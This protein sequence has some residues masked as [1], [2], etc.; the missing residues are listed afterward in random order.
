MKAILPPSKLTKG[1][2]PKLI[3]ICNRGEFLVESKEAKQ[4]FALVVKEEVGPAI[5]VPEKIKPMLEKFQR[6][7]HDELRTNYH[8]EGYPAPYWFDPRSE[9]TQSLTL[10]D[11]SKREWSSKGE[12]QR[13]DSERDTLER[14][15]VHAQYRLFWHQRRMEWTAEPSTR[16]LSDIDS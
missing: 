14:A 11:E 9:S 7:V 13:A 15:W 4:W 1:E 3:S 6:I 10:M 8:H 5:E 12:G 2:E 16:S